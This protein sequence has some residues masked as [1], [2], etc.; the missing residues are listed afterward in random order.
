MVPGPARPVSVQCLQV[1]G[2]RTAV[3]TLC[4]RERM[5][6]PDQRQPFRRHRLTDDRQ[7]H[8][9][10]ETIEPD[11][12]LRVRVWM[13]YVG[14]FEGGRLVS[15]YWRPQPSCTYHVELDPSAEEP[16]PAHAAAALSASA[17]PDTLIRSGS[18]RLSRPSAATAKLCT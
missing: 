15:I 12:S 7:I 13:S 17:R 3:A 6:N 5:L 18:S 4:P 9:V 10:Q 2:R 11:L 8:S 14:H 1:S 16:R